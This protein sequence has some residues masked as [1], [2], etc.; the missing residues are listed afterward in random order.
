MTLCLEKKQQIDYNGND[1]F[2]RQTIFLQ[3]VNFM[4]QTFP[5]VIPKRAAVINDLT[6]FGRCSL[7]V[8]LPII[9]AMKVQA[10][11]VP[12]SVFSN[13][14]GFHSYYYQDLT[15]GLSSY[16]KGYDSL[17]LL[18]DGIYCGF[19]NSPRQSQCVR[20]FL[21]QQ[22]HQASPLVLLDPVMGDHGKTYRIVTAAL[23]QEM[24]SLVSYATILTPN[25]TEA[26]LL[27]DTKYPE[28]NVS[29]ALLQEIS[30]KLHEMGPSKVAITGIQDDTNVINYCS[31]KKQAGIH[32]FSYQTPCNGESRPGTGDIFASILT[33]D[34]LNGHSFQHSVQKAADFI[35]LCVNASSQAGVPIQEGVIFENYL[36]LLWEEVYEN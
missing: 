20:R 15:D 5:A 17:G 7:A 16:L 32:T 30:E 14:M 19:L 1:C 4:K 8:V 31:E 13:H 22:S 23:C 26:C 11:P 25:L 3:K 36:A 18:F 2:D 27:T 21:K 28:K 34:A 9:N 10:C 35:S 6:G 33:A 24:K 12:T 29:T